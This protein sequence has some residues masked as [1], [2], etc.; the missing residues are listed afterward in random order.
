MTIGVF[1]R[2]AKQTRRLAAISAVISGATLASCTGSPGGP[3]PYNVQNFG[4]PDPARPAV[5]P[6]DYKIMAE[7]VLTVIVYQVE[8][9]SRDYKVDPSGYISF[10]LIGRVLADGLTS[11]QLS[12]SLAERLNQRYLRNPQVS[13]SVKETPAR[14]F[15]VDGSVNRPGV[16]PIVGDMSL[17]QAV[18]TA[19][20]PTQFANFHRVGIFRRVNGQRMA[21]AFDL[22]LIRTGEAEDPRVYPGDVIVMG[23][24][25]TRSAFQEILAT[26]PILALFRPY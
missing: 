2:A 12:Q 10:P 22:G 25:T 1:Q 26:L 9:L 5:L 21:A 8:D 20:G 13:V 24:S 17:T 4:A 7:D 11:E 15:T 6:A 16:Y 23:G 19:Q 14:N 18:A 3:I